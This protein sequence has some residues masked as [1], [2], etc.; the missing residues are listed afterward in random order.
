MGESFDVS[1]G[2]S[3]SY[4]GSEF[5]DCYGYCHVRTLNLA[6]D[7]CFGKYLA[8]NVSTAALLLECAGH[9]SPDLKTGVG[10]PKFSTR[11]REASVAITLALDDFAPGRESEFRELLVELID[12]A[13][14]KIV[15]HKRSLKIGMDVA[16]LA[17]RWQL[18]RA[19]YLA[20]PLPI[21]MPAPSGAVE[22]VVPDCAE[23]Y[24]E[25]E[26]KK[27]LLEFNKAL[28]ARNLR[29]DWDDESEDGYYVVVEDPNSP[30]LNKQFEQELI[31]LA[32]EHNGIYDGWAAL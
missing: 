11:Y 27:D 30:K 1:C 15:N 10:E 26:Q 7:K 23:Y 31:A 2:I 6:F 4:Y 28:I 19:E 24:F 13:I 32:E 3:A 16:L 22:P 14:S 12:Q 17:S 25:F 20:E 8:E 18:L 5:V 21:E 9:F 29:A